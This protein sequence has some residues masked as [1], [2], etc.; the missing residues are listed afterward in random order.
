[1]AGYHPSGSGEAENFLGSLEVTT[2]GQGQAVFDVP[3]TA[4]VDM[5]Y[6]TAT[7]TDPRGNTSE[8]SALRRGSLEAPQQD[9][10]LAADVPAGF[11]TTSGDG[12]VLRDPDAGP[13]DP[14]WNLTLSVPV[15]TL[16]LSTT[17]GLV[18]AGDGTGSADFRGALSALDAALEGLNYAAP[19]GFHG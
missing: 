2:D 9:I 4:P 6:I 5:P 14:V 12:I 3:F 19:P 16:T 7:A 10:R 1:S 8:V 15:G 11:S 13:L 18:G 17:A